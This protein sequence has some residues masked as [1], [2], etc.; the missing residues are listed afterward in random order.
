MH[1]VVVQ[2]TANSTTFGW[3]EG[4]E[5]LGHRVTLLT[6]TPKLQFGGRPGA[7]LRD[8]PDSPPSVRIAARSRLAH[9]LVDGLPSPRAV[10]AALADLRPD[11]ALVKLD[12][13]R[14]MVIGRELTRRGVPW[15]L[16]QEQLPPLSRRWR[17]AALLGVR[18]AA[19]FTALDAR[20]GGV[21]VPE[22]AGSM[23][24]ISY[25]P[26]V[27]DRVGTPAPASPSA[28]PSAPASAPASPRRGAGPARILVVASFKNH[29][30]KRP[31]W[32]LEAAA[33]EGLLDG[34]V[35][36]TFAGQGGAQHVGHQRIAELVAAHRAEH[37]V[38]LR[39]NVPFDE[40]GALYRDHDVVVLPSRREQFGMAVVE[41]MAHGLPTIVSDAVGAIGCVVDGVTGIVF[42]VD[43]R[44]ALGRAM[45]RL[46]TD[47]GLRSALG[48]A[49]SRFVAEHLD[50]AQA[51]RR[52]LRLALPED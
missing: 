47:D 38:E 32:V 37:L 6:A 48:G 1:V 20:P 11:V 13:A 45:A 25:T 49:A 51:A 7:Q 23:P 9:R 12:K 50:S 35:T 31:W 8:V 24:R 21:A 29:A 44:A 41:G 34:R 42:P 40:M 46:V 36:F 14:N 17:A 30:A 52:I 3:E 2:P 27:P 4:F 39:S 18:P 33:D 16:W 26:Y 28:S 22:P 15:V 19:T 5:R 43:D 10:R